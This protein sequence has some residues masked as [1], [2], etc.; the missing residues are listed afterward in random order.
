MG[1]LTFGKKEEQI[2]LGREISQHRDYSEDTAIR[3]DQEVKRIVEE[4]YIRANKTLE[5][6]RESLVRLAEALLE[7]ETLDSSDIEAIIKGQPMK[8]KITVSSDTD[9]EGEPAR[10]KPAGHAPLPQLINPKGK[11]A[12][13]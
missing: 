9:S 7:Y 13:A 8:P 6:N 3:I 12:P 1:P 4:G 11:P 2:F 10:E 5:E